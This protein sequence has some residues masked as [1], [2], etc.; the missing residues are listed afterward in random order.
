M[1]DWRKTH[2]GQRMIAWLG[3]GRNVK[4]D[5]L[6]GF[7]EQ[8]AAA[9]DMP[10]FAQTAPAGWLSYEQRIVLADDQ[11]ESERMIIRFN[12]PLLLIGVMFVITTTSLEDDAAGIPTLDQMDVQIDFNRQQEFAT[13]RIDAPASIGPNGYAPC[14]S[15]DI[16]LP[17]YFMKVCPDPNGETGFTFRGRYA[18]SSASGFESDI[19]I[20][21][22]CFGK[23]LNTRES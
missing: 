16:R 19:L 7:I 8:R 21:T 14:S 12:E 22:I 3:L 23:P 17:R 10:L 11:T 2:W 1:V 18:T 20:S 4:L 5:E 15:Q 9:F 13:S 6:V